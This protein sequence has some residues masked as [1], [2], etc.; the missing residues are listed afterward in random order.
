MKYEVSQGAYADFLNTLGRSG[1]SHRANF[2]SPGHANASGSIV[3]E[4]GSYRF[5]MG[6][7]Q[8]ARTAP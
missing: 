3:P 5:G 7:F 6:G 4:D 8:A 2:G 1:T